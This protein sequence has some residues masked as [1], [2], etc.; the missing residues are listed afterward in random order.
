MA[1]GKFTQHG[2]QHGKDARCHVSD[3]YS[4]HFATIRRLGELDRFAGAREHGS[5]LLEKGAS[6][7]RERHLA[8]GARKQTDTEFSFERADCQRQ[9]R[10]GDGQAARCTS[11]VKFLGERDEVAQRPEFHL[12]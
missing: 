10:L 5:R 2:R 9:G 11:E 3:R 12:D 4:P 8:A 1:G 6:G 7:M